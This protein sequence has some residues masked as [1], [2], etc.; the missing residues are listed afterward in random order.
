MLF[1]EKAFSLLEVLF[2][3]VII[4]IIGVL[5]FSIQSSSWRRVMS[6]NR[7][8]VAG[9]MIERQIES[10]RMIISRDQEHNFP[11]VSGSTVENGVT[12][13]W[14]ISTATRPTG[15]SQDNSRQCDFTASWGLGKN[16]TMKAT[17]YLS[18]MF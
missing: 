11:P 4:G 10:M 15:G 2:S 8:L 1:N 9:H 5:I 14:L 7:T 6:S 13:N 12:L 3:M 16:D 18:K 17:T